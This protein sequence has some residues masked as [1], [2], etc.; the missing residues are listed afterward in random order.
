MTNQEIQQMEHKLIFRK[1][2]FGS[3]NHIFFT[4]AKEV[5]EN[6]YS[7]KDKYYV[8]RPEMFDNHPY[9]VKRTISP[10]KSYIYWSFVDEVTNCM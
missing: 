5:E 7:Y 2:F 4:L 9:E 3:D 1:A 6:V 8:Y 10:K